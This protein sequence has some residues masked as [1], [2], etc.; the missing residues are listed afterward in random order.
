MGAAARQCAYP[1]LQPRPGS[2]R[3][4]RGL[5]AEHATLPAR[6]DLDYSEERFR[7]LHVKIFNYDDQPLK[8]SDARVYGYPRY[9]LFRHEPGKS[10][11]LFYSNPAAAAPRYDLEQLSPYLKLEQLAMLKLAEE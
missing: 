9:L 4:D 3:F 5:S 7:Y 8:L 1:R 2:A 11:R 6:G 10:Y